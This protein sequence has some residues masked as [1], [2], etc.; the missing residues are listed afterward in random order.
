[1]RHFPSPFH[2]L[3]WL[4]AVKTA[5]AGYM[6]SWHAGF[7]APQIIMQD[8]QT[9]KLFHSYC[10][11]SDGS[12][13]F[14]E[15]DFPTLP[16]PDELGPRKGT[17][18]ATT[19]YANGAD[20]TAVVNWQMSNH[21]IVHGLFICNR[22]TG[23]FDLVPGAPWIISGGDNPDPNADSGLAM[24]HLEGESGY[25]VYYQDGSKAVVA[26]RYTQ[27]DNWKPAGNVS[28]DAIQGFHIGAGSVGKS[29]ITV[30]APRDDNNIEISTVLQDNGTWVISTFPT[31]LEPV[32]RPEDK[33]KLDLAPTNF[34]LARNFTL[35]TKAGAELSLDGWFYRVSGMAL[36][37]DPQ[38]TRSIFYMGNDSKVHQITEDNG[39][40]KLADRPDET[41]WPDADSPD[42]PF[43]VTYDNVG[44]Q[45][46]MYYRSG[47]SMTQIYR[48][49]DG[50]DE[51]SPL[52]SAF[53][54]AEKSSSSGLSRGAKAGIGV[55]VSIGG[56]ALIALGAYIFLQRR[57]GKQEKAAAAAGDAAAQAHLSLPHS[58]APA[59]ASGAPEGQWINGQWVPTAA[60]WQQQMKDAS[61]KPEWQQQQHI[62]EMVGQH[63]HAQEMA[64]E[65]SYYEMPASHHNGTDAPSPSV[66]R[67]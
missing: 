36:T 44:G 40:W 17:G 30:V 14:P 31:P 39:D 16:I 46:W 48:S 47:G 23:L 8:D 2:S 52:P 4:L 60:L 28:Q 1:M 11:S 15:S 38:G 62:P 61:V 19:G 34:T 22:T 27:S 65:T 20:M 50:W 43:A 35:D 18:L 5:W 26:L 53:P 13:V 51:A 6:T 63:V 54:T 41:K 56:L 9:G 55:G 64:H 33:I 32:D 12:P 49:M 7:D 58:P 66:N 67:E 59:Y 24:V 29:T 57:R 42:T 21:S 10:N 45:I 25:Q 37:F 3:I